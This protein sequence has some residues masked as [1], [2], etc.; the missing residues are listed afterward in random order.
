[1]TTAE[2]L[3]RI[4]CLLKHCANAE[5]DGLENSLAHFSRIEEDAR[6]IEDLLITGETE[7]EVH[8]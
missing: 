2:A 8:L 4:Q 7:R 5:R 3:P 6:A 1:M